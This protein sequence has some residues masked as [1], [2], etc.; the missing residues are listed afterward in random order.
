[1]ERIKIMFAHRCKI[2]IEGLKFIFNADDFDT[3]GQ[4]YDE[5]NVMMGVRTLK[6]D[7]LIV[8]PEL[9]KT[10]SGEFIKKLKQV[11]Q[12]TKVVVL[13]DTD[14]YDYIYECVGNGA[15]GFIFEDG[16]VENSK[17]VDMVR[18]LYKLDMVCMPKPVFKNLVDQSNDRRL[19]GAGP[20]KLLTPRE[21]E[22]YML[23]AKNYSNHEIGKAL[24]ISEATVKSHVSS[25]LRKF[26]QPSRSKAVLY[27][28]QNGVFNIRTINKMEVL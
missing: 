28:F 17:I 1:M 8:N 4:A 21:R 10:D 16:D 11:G 9:S 13:T 24:F 26:K 19:N 18:L 27:G 7:I 25:I 3:I 20:L 23:M 2:V 6:P 14:D 22:V 15:D 5:K 12:S